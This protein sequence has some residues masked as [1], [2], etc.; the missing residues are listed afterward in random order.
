MV[1]QDV[2]G[3]FG[4]ASL[5]GAVS[6]SLQVTYTANTASD[7][8]PHL[9]QVKL[10]ATAAA[11]AASTSV[12]LTSCRSDGDL[13]LE[14]HAAWCKA[15]YRSSLSL[16]K[17]M[18]PTDSRFLLFAMQYHRGPDFVIGP[19]IVITVLSYRN[20]PQ[21]RHGLVLCPL[22]GLCEDRVYVAGFLY[23]SNQ[24]LPSLSRRL[25]DAPYKSL[26]L[27]LVASA[28]KEVSSACVLHILLIFS[29]E[30]GLCHSKADFRSS[31][32][33]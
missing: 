1:I 19:L 4:C 14:R 11:Q 9:L 20:S 24:K 10:A 31:I 15:D 25:D 30:L 33:V 29:L 3:N 18:A 6:V 22:C 26:Y 27:V 2:S 12:Y 23:L 28:A 13:M 16:F 17:A 21:H 5:P 32:S 8:S 7:R